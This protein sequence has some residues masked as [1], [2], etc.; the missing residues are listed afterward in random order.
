MEFLGISPV[1]LVVILVILFLV[2]GPQDLVK[3]GSTMGRTIRNL[4]ESG[5][6]RSIQDAR[7]QLRELPDQ[8]AKEAGYE[9]VKKLGS[10]L[11]EEIKETRVALDDLDHQIV[12]WTRQPESLSQKKPK[13]EKPAEDSGREDK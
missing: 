3:L 8:L 7:R 9:D 12:A 4:R 6:W 2:L 11:R 13:E 1:E 5:A 10:K